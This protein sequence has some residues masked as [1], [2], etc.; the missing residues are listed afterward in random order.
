MPPNVSE[1]LRYSSTEFYLFQNTDGQFNG[2]E[3]RVL[4]G[5]E[6]EATFVNYAE[7][8]AEVNGRNF[9][10]LNTQ[11]PAH[12]SA[13][14]R[15][16]LRNSFV[17]RMSCNVMQQG[18]DWTVGMLLGLRDSTLVEELDVLVSKN[19]MHDSLAHTELGFLLNPSVPSLL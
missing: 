5:H 4:L 3:P 12:S 11:P 19:A 14:I 15:R 1:A 17:K 9:L 7:C 16:H 18:F 13:V 10:F 2:R 6:W 8:F